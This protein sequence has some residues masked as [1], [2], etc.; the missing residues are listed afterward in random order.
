MVKWAYYLKNCCIS[1]DGFVLNLTMCKE[2]EG[3]E[4][5]IFP[6]K[7]AFKEWT[8]CKAA[9]VGYLHSSSGEGCTVLCSGHLSITFRMCKY[10]HAKFNFQILSE[11]SHNECRVFCCWLFWLFAFPNLALWWCPTLLLQIYK[12]PIEV[13][14][15]SPYLFLLD[16]WVDKQFA[17]H[18][19]LSKGHCCFF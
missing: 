10:L 1:F 17:I 2:K 16:F 6:L 9:Q 18:W 15:T 12:G 13:V 19:A 11:L 7:L 4:R 8:L 14:L 3:M 5:K